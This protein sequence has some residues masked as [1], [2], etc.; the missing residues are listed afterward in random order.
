MYK[1]IPT[2]GNNPFPVEEK[3]FRL[4]RIPISNIKV[5]WRDAENCGKA[6]DD[7]LKKGNYRA[8]VKTLEYIET[9]KATEQYV[10]LY[11]ITF[12]M[13]LSKSAIGVLCYIFKRVT[14]KHTFVVDYEDMIAFTHLSKRSIERGLQELRETGVVA[15]RGGNVCHINPNLFCKGKRV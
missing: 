2:Y 6:K 13:Y 14:T 15:Q 4:V 11:D 7:I 10:K 8:R 5:E 3:D 12:M 9:M 1:K